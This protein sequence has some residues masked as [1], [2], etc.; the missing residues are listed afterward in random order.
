MAITKKQK[1]SFSNYRIFQYS[2][3]VRKA[4]PI[5]TALL[6]PAL[7]NPWAGPLFEG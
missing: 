3:A 5:E 2:K 7:I 1:L 6:V 4:E